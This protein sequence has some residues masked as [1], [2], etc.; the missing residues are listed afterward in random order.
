VIQWVTV[1][2]YMG[3]LGI[4]FNY[5]DALKNY[6]EEALKN[7]RISGEIILVGPKNEES[8]LTNL[9]SFLIPDAV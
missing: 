3:G 6:L 7:E 8:N 1:L 4:A 9:L 2:E 5:N